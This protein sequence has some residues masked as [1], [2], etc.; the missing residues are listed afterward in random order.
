[1]VMC[2]PGMHEALVNLNDKKIASVIFK[3]VYDNFLYILIN[4]K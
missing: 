4:S 1:M 2:L 3:I